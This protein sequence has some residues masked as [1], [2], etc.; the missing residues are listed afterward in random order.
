MQGLRTSGSHSQSHSPPA[1]GGTVASR[2]FGKEEQTRRCCS[3]IDRWAWDRRGVQGSE[4]V[5]QTEGEGVSEFT[6]AGTGDR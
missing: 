4:R 5:H 3:A 2:T 1:P 6:K